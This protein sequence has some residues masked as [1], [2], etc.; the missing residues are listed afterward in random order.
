MDHDYDDGII[1]A[2]WQRSNSQR[3][4]VCCLWSVSSCQLSVNIQWRL[5]TGFSHLHTVVVLPA[6]CSCQHAEC[7]SWSHL[8]QSSGAA[9]V[10]AVPTLATPSAV[11]S[12]SSRSG[13]QHESGLDTRV[14]IQPVFTVVSFASAGGEII[15]T[16]YMWSLLLTCLLHH[17]QQQQYLAATVP[18]W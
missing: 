3:S 11:W 5:R 4:A 18:G 8:Q 10:A 13:C 14:V 12:W 7:H 6:S 15:S 9:E 16:C 2:A 17:D 1:I